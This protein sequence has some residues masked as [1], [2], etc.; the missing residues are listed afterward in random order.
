MK[1]KLPSSQPDHSTP[2]SKTPFN[3][4]V[5]Y[6]DVPMGVRAKHVLD[7]IGRT[8]APDCHLVVNIWKFSMLHLTE[9]AESA[10]IEAVAAD[11]IILALREDN[12]VPHETKTWI[13]AWLQ[14][15]A[16]AAGALV[17]LFD[18]DNQPSVSARS[19]HAYLEGV[20]K[21]SNLDVFALSDEADWAN[22]QWLCLECGRLGATATP[23]HSVGALAIS[24]P[25]E[26]DGE[27]APAFN[28]AAATAELA[29]AIRAG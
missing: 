16:S 19:A 24:D 18:P 4:V 17:L 21:R 7:S 14:R 6:D 20:G 8:L 3:V 10:V 5:A 13:E 1:P 2:G 9:L 15:R 29:Q 28:H 12:G 23:K 25:T 26:L 27:N 22:L 11:M